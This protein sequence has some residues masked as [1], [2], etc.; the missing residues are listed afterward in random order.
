M[1]KR[2]KIYKF[3]HKLKILFWILCEKSID[4]RTL[5]MLY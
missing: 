4:E 1:E 5:G 2:E 3:V